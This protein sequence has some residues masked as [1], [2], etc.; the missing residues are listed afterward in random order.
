MERKGRDMRVGF[1]AC[2]VVCVAVEKARCDEMCGLGKKCAGRE[3]QPQAAVQQ[4]SIAG[5]D[6]DE[7]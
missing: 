1:A 3:R 7:S 6:I 5:N 4:S 2:G